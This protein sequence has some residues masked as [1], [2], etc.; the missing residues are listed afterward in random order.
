MPQRLVKRCSLSLSLGTY[1]P[2]YPVPDD[3]SLEAYLE[4]L[5]RQGLEARLKKLFGE[6][7]CS[8]QQSRVY[9]DRRN[10]AGRHQPDG[11]SRLL[12]DCHGVYSLGKRE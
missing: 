10:G 3:R 7:G 2:N 11:V 9:F 8:E 12:P 4:D 1:L 6:S 5:S